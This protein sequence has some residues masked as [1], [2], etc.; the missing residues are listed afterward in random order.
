MPGTL[1][2]PRGRAA[3]TGRT[4]RDAAAELVPLL[5][6]SA[7]AIDAS[8]RLTQDVVSAMDAAGIYD[9]GYPVEFEGRDL[10]IGDVLEVLRVLSRGSGSAG[11]SAAINV[12]QSLLFHGIERGALEDVFA[13][14]HV[15]PRV[16]GSLLNVSLSEGF[17]QKVDGGFM[18][19]GSWAFSSNVRLA[20]WQA[21]TFGWSDGGEFK[22]SMML[23]PRR[24]FKIAD[25]WRVTGLKG[26]GSNSAYIPEEVFVPDHRTVPIETFL[27][28]LPRGGQL[29]LALLN[30][31]I[32]LGMA[33]GALELF[34]EKARKRA[35][36]GLHYPTI[37]DM[38]STHALVAKA[39]GEINTSATIIFKLADDRAQSKPE[40]MTGDF[41]AVQAIHR[42][43]GVVDELE[44]TIGSS[45]AADT[46]SIGR[47]ARDMRVLSLHH[48][49][50]IAWAAEVAGQ[51]ILGKPNALQ[52]LT[53]GN[54]ATEAVRTEPRILPILEH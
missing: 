29:S 48:A 19:R 49:H 9:L 15:G 7:E 14:P 50:R 5:R 32:A 33:E 35:P 43:R 31:A 23:V 24:D 46:D 10:P 13:A 22:R 4:I 11:W 51:T 34:I 37:A 41:E 54:M 18:I 6:R 20:A 27:K 2:T 28:R 39:T 21:G 52:R 53:Q 42:L 26:T 16:A 45:C 38:P 25:D 3:V 36:W 44:M 17:G 47:F 1:D 30:S 8:G 40:G 12:T